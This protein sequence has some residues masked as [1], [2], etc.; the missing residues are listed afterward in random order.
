MLGALRK[1]R[2]LGLAEHL[3]VTNFIQRREEACVHV[4]CVYA[5]VRV[6][7]CTCMHAHKPVNYTT[8]VS[9]AGESWVPEEP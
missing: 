9:E 7:G 3:E 5:R 2:A 8:I 6:H 4:W 1:L